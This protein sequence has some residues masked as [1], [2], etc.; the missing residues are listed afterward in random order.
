M[1]LKKKI[2]YICLGLSLCL[3]AVNISVKAEIP[4]TSILLVGI[5]PNELSLNEQMH[6]SGKEVI[7]VPFNNHWQDSIQKYQAQEIILKQPSGFTGL[8]MPNG[9]I[10]RVVDLKIRPNHPYYNTPPAPAVRNLQPKHWKQLGYNTGGRRDPYRAQAVDR[11][12]KL[13]PG[14][15]YNRDLNPPK[16]K[17]QVFLDFLAY[18]PLD[19]ATPFNYPGTFDAL[20][21]SGVYLTGS[22]PHIGG[23]IQE[24][25][26][27]K[28]N[29]QRYNE[30]LKQTPQNDYTEQPVQYYNE[31]DPT[32]PISSDPN[33]FRLQ[34][35][36]EAFTKNYP[37]YEHKANY[38][39]QHGQPLPLDR[40]GDG[41]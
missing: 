27:A 4:S 41:T 21:L 13:A 33:Q 29:Q 22:L 20:N 3:S 24:T 5:K 15:G 2:I 25:Q 28:A 1:D 37:N 7:E 26:R 11:H 17:R 39:Q 18:S 8:Y 10:V 9:H 36:P 31:A 38:Y 14:W 34:Q 16:T 19:P 32:N 23:L 40:I 6:L 30:L 35:M 12:A